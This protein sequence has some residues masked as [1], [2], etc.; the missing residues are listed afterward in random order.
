MF[1]S[2]LE[3][4]SQ[5]VYEDEYGAVSEGFCNHDEEILEMKRSILKIGHL[6]V[7]QVLTLAGLCLLRKASIQHQ[8]ATSPDLH[9][10][11]SY[12]TALVTSCPLKSSWLTW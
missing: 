1:F 12:W 8:S 3:T 5:L 11:A 4:F 7:S 9:T 10:E 6:Y 2:G